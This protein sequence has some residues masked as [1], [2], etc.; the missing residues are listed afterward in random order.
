M[1]LGRFR[2]WL[3]ATFLGTDRRVL[4]LALARMVDGFGNSFL[5]V[6]LPLYIVGPVDVAPLLGVR[7]PIVGLSLTETLLVGIVLSLYGFLSSIGQP[8]AG[9]LSDRTGR[10]KVYI[11]LGLALLGAANAAYAVVTDYRLLIGLRALQ[12][13]SAALTIPCSVALINDLGGAL[14]RGGNFG[15]YNTFRLVG[16]GFGPVVAGV[17]VEAGP[18]VLAIGGL[19]V[20]LGRFDAVFWLAA[21]SAAVGFALVAAFVSEPERTRATA[22]D[23]LSL[24]VRHPERRQLLDPVFAVGVATLFM[25][26]G[27]ALFETLASPINARLGQ[28][29]TLF[30]VQFAAAVVANVLL[31]T[32]IG[33]A[34]D[35]Y[36]RRPFLLAG[37]TLLVPATL[38]Q[39]LVLELAAVV[40]YA[41][42]VMVAVRFLQG[43]AIALVFAPALSLAGD[44]AR[45]GESG[46]RLSVLT[47]AF[48]L[49]VAIGPL[50]SGV[51]ARFG[52]V[53]PFAFGAALGGLGL[54]VVYTQVYETVEAATT[55]APRTA[56][57]QDD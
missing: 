9:R 57:P 35:R 56:V 45:E 3:V 51:L 31:Q 43:V 49:G 52:I 10:R 50:T 39:G 17:L 7:V 44:L 24:R 15:I 37:F 48:T 29:G 14:D 40:P 12:G 32:P 33:Q 36:G 53:W 2:R 22:A 13:L 11:L 27:L 28:G 54:L 20:E 42:A 6:V 4:V 1:V 25:A 21:L 34:S 18:Y 38:A 5:I 19:V 8:I 47:T 26:I 46:T 41:P 55:G 23:D 30:A 16:F